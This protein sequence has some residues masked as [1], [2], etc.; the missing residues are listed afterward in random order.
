MRM[1][2]TAERPPA[3]D[4]P[5]ARN[6]ERR[7]DTSRIHVA[8]GSSCGP[9]ALCGWSPPPLPADTTLKSR[10]D[11]ILVGNAPALAM[12]VI[13]LGLLSLAPHL[14]VRA[15]LAVDGLVSFVGGAWCSLNFWRCRHAHCLVTGT[16]WLTLSMFAFVECG[17][18]HSIIGGDEQPVFLGVLAAALVFEY[19]W[20]LAR[21]TNAIG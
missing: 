7:N 16:G 19:A 1:T 6:T 3:E 17:L 9:R 10:V 13:V 20:Y 21:H 15:G 4:D 2:R 5:A 18:G 12:L 14:P 11:R 8:A